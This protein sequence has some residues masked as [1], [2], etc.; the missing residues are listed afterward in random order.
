[1]VNNSMVIDKRSFSPDWV[2][3]NGQSENSDTT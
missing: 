2:D 3:P 1:M